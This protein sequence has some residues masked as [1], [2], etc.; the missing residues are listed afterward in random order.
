MT[1]DEFIKS[2]S[3]EGEEWKTIPGW[4]RYTVSTFGRIAAYS[5]PYLCGNRT[6]YREP[7]LI[8]PRL[9]DSAPG[10]YSVV[11]SDG[12]RHRKSFV[13]HRLVAMTFI[14]NPDNLPFVNHKDEN[15]RNNYANNLEWCT[16]QYNCNYGTHNARMA[17]TI[18]E[19]AYQRRKVVW[20]SLSNKLLGIF[21]S[22]KEAAIAANVSRA[23]VSICCR[24]IKPSLCGYKWMYFSDYKSLIN[25]PKNTLPIRTISPNN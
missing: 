15:S 23:S 19:T 13:V 21:N 22:I 7:Q 10:Y 16:Q 3:L 1:N 6:C 2:I 25:K 18:S 5:A 11:L 4:E 12:N 8:K 24:K 14:P 9:G 20:L 17:K